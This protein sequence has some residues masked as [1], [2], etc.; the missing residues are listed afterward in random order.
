MSHL[1]FDC[2]GNT[3]VNLLDE[4]PGASLQATNVSY[5]KAMDGGE[6]VS[7]GIHRDRL[8]LLDGVWIIRHRVID[9]TWTKAGGHREVGPCL[10]T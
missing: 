2:Q 6:I 4:V 9:H 7:T 5:W 10:A 8:V 3:V 1:A